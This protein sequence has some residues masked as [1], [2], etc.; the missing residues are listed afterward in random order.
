[1][2]PHKLK[3]VI[4]T[5]LNRQVR[6]MAGLAGLTVIGLARTKIGEFELGGLESGQYRIVS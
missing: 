1:M 5:G 3:L 6:R 2:A 4:T